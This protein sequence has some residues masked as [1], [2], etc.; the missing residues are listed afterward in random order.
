LTILLGVPN[1]LLEDFLGLF[2]ELAVQVDGVTVD[3]AHGVVFAE[4][5]LGGLLVVFVGFGSMRLALLRQLMRLAAVAA[6]VGL[7]GTRG[8]RLVLALLF[9]SKVAEAVILALGI[10]RRTVVEGW[11]ALSVGK[12]CR[13]CVL[14]RGLP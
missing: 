13:H 9:T 2:D 8:E 1:A 14:M 3:F 10:T 5:E 7:L 11:R 12:S 6:L 4:D